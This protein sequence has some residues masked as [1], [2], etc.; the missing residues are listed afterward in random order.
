MPSVVLASAGY[1]HTIR[2]WEAPSGVCYRTVQY[3]DSQLNCLK[4]TPDK[5]YLAAAGN[6]HVR[7]FDINSN[8]P[9]AVTSCDG[10]TSNVTSIGFQKS[11]KWMFTASEDHTIKLWDLR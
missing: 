5:V 3:P 4:I 1:D 6:P 2:F 8:N 10:H 7:L 9:N 11:G